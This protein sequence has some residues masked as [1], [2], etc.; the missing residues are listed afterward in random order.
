LVSGWQETAAWVDVG[1]GC[2]DGVLRGAVEVLVGV[3]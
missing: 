3:T 2:G 1:V